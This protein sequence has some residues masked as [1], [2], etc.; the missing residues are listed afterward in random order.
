VIFEVPVVA[1]LLAVKVSVELPLPGAAI[2]AGLKLA[3]T[4]AGN[5]DAESEIA[6][7]KPPLAAVEIIVLALPPCVSDVLVG[8][9]LTLKSAAAP[10]LKTILRTG[11][12]SIWFG[13][14]PVCPWGKSNIPTPVTCT[15]MLA[16]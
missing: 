8:D 4:P 7:L 3:V 6:E 12:N 14:A 11:C 1:V 10:G 16:V 2:E 5:P 15:G 13:A 9:A